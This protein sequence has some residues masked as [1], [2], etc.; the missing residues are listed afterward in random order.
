MS[1]SE[2]DETPQSSPR[3]STQR[4]RER[5]EDER[6]P[7]RE[8]IDP[9]TSLQLAQEFGRSARRRRS[10]LS[11]E[12]DYAAEL[13]ERTTRRSLALQGHGEVEF[14]LS[15]DRARRLEEVN[16]GD[17]ELVAGVVDTHF[18][19]VSD[20]LWNLLSR[21]TKAEKRVFLMTG[22][23]LKQRTSEVGEIVSRTAQKEGFGRST[24]DAIAI[25][26]ERREVVVAARVAFQAWRN[27]L[28]MTLEVRAANA[29][30]TSVAARLNVVKTTVRTRRDAV[31]MASE[32]I[33]KN[34]RKPGRGN[35]DMIV[36]FLNWAFAV[37]EAAWEAYARECE[38]KML[39]LSK[40]A[41]D[42]V[43]WMEKLGKSASM[44]AAHT[45]GVEFGLSYDEMQERLETAGHKI[46][47]AWT[48]RD[49]MNLLRTTVGRWFLVAWQA[50]DRR[51]R[52]EYDRRAKFQEHQAL[53]QSVDAIA[54]WLAAERVSHI[55]DRV[56]AKWHDRVLEK[57]TVLQ[58]VGQRLDVA[59]GLASW[60]FAANDRASLNVVFSHWRQVW[61]SGVHK[62]HISEDKESAKG[63]TKFFVELL[64]TSTKALELRLFFAKWHK[65]ARTLALGRTGETLAWQL[66]KAQ[67]SKDGVAQLFLSSQDI[68]LR[69]IIFLRW[70]KATS[71]ALMDSVALKQREEF[72]VQLDDQRAQG[73]LELEEAERRQQAIHESLVK[74]QS[75]ATEHQQQLLQAQH[76]HEE[77][78]RLAAEDQQRLE[79]RHVEQVAGIAR[80]AEEMLQKRREAV[81]KCLR[82][83]QQRVLVQITY[84]TWHKLWE[85]AAHERRNEELA[86]Q[87]RRDFE[88]MQE[89]MRRA[90]AAGSANAQEQREKAAD[91]MYEYHLQTLMRDLLDTWHDSAGDQAEQRRM[92]DELA[93]QRDQAA[94]EQEEALRR[95]NERIAAQFNEARLERWCSQVLQAWHM[96]ASEEHLQELEAQI[97]DDAKESK[98]L[99]ELETQEMDIVHERREEDVRR[100]L[101]VQAAEM[102]LQSEQSPPRRRTFTRGS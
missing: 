12:G 99:V 13:L 74:A 101:S 88:A 19:D 69:A 100:R 50:R 31:R 67:R 87:H 11:E 42:C 25:L 33:L 102:R 79:A 40:A 95:Q 1:D 26:L 4:R 92:D 65:L 47:D 58:A 55:V 96:E 24:G 46:A 52:G 32:R 82:D 64:Y 36:S 45:S 34:T 30:M 93:K 39:R 71:A 77:D 21:V 68:Y 89:Q 18:R 17:M 98:R 72:L 81:G 28:A 59:S 91:R 10:S 35:S 5:S 78:L 56:F 8:L 53:V 16:E 62:Q 44:N 14:V 63:R 66:R 97:Q 75:L 15:S 80:E 22:G 41:R 84:S 48:L 94:T 85:L 51:L 38:E 6:D 49:N 86:E 76:R 20:K 60:L 54:L 73:Q 57:K 90:E 37:R 61:Q 83:M 9:P 3:S 2:E 43:L 27:A 23:N 70:H 7:E 29:R